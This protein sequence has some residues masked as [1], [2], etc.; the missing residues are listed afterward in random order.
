MQERNGTEPDFE[1]TG[2]DFQGHL[3]EVNGADA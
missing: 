2:G 1:M 3:V